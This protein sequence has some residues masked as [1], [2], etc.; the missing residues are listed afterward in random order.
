MPS[1]RPSWRL[2]RAASQRHRQSA[3]V[4]PSCVRRFSAAADPRGSK[5]QEDA[6]LQDN[7]DGVWPRIKLVK[8]L[9]FNENARDILFQTIEST[10]RIYGRPMPLPAMPVKMYTDLRN[11]L[12][13]K[14]NFDP[15]DFLEGAETA[16]SNMMDIVDPSRTT[17]EECATL[18]DDITIS[19][20]KL[21]FLSWREFVTS[22]R[23]TPL[24]P[25]VKALFMTGVETDVV[26]VEDE[27]LL[28]HLFPSLG[29]EVAVAT[30]AEETS[31]DIPDSNESHLSPFSKY[32]L[33]SVI[34]TVTVEAVLLKGDEDISS[35]PLLPDAMKDDYI[36]V[37][38][39]FKG[40]ISGQKKMEWKISKVMFSA[41]IVALTAPPKDSVVQEGRSDANKTT[42]EGINK[43]ALTE[44]E[45]SGSGGGVGEDDSEKK[46]ERGTTPSV[47][48]KDKSANNRKTDDGNSN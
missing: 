6:E 41:P 3:L 13:T 26:S 27:Q 28:K 32:P 19:D 24:Y 36:M 20:V 45:E 15:N 4:T 5:E 48:G 39:D 16:L 23:A 37:M 33:G 18:L 22:D 25:K 7:F 14:Y 10:T 9:F 34:A 40:C 29:A 43:A 30:G 46:G 8:D 35:V 17:D 2:F 44:R 31:K 12:L 42:D 21:G 11:P 1:L 38:I 47:G